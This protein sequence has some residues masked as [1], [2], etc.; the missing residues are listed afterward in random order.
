MWEDPIAAALQIIQETCAQA[1]AGIAV[2]PTFR[3]RTVGTSAFG[4]RG[5]SLIECIVYVFDAKGTNV[6]MAHYVS[7]L[8]SFGPTDVDGYESLLMEYKSL[9]AGL[10]GLLFE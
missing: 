3:V 5:S 10:I 1:E 7:D 2:V 8:L 4:I 9:A 6:G